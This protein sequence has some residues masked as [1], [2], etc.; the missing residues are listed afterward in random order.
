MKRFII[1]LMLLSGIQATVFNYAASTRSTDLSQ[2][3]TKKVDYQ[4]SDYQ[5]VSK[6]Q[7]CELFE[8]HL[9]R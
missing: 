9:N 5:E 2:V 4:C 3:V 6:K 8:A 7:L 1:S